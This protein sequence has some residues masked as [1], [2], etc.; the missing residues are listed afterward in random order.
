MAEATGAVLDIVEDPKQGVKGADAIYTDV[1]TSMGQEQEAAVRREVF[2]PYQVNAALLAEAPS[3]AVVMHCLPAHRG[4]EIT[5]EVLES[6]RS[7]AFEEAENR[8]HAQKALLVFTMI[9]L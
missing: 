6:D 5:E 4:E 1:W 3:H 7:L 9:G 8:L 2:R